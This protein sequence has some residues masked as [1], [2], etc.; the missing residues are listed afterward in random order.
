M[1]GADRDPRVIEVQLYGDLH[2]Q[3]FPIR[4]ASTARANQ[5]YGWVKVSVA[6]PGAGD[7]EA[8]LHLEGLG[9]QVDGVLK[10]LRSGVE[11]IRIARMVAAPAGSEGWNTFQIMQ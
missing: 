3:T 11:G 1:S 8:T 10:W 6:A 2:D 5:V 4:C 7:D 9:Y